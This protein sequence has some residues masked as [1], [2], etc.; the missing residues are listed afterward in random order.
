M[1]MD[2]FNDLLGRMVT[3]LGAASNATMV[4]TGDRLGLYHAL[5]QGPATSTE[6]AERTGTAERYV[7]EWLAAQAAGGYIDYSPADERYSLSPEQAFLLADN[8]GMDVPGA[9]YVT[10]A[11]FKALDRT[12]ENFRTGEGMEWGE[13]DACLFCGT[14]RFFRAGYNAHLLSEWLPALDGA[15]AKLSAGG[16]VLDVGCGHGSSTLLMARAYPASQFI[17]I[18]YHE[19]SIETARMKAADAGLTNVQFTVADAADFEERNLDLVAFF[20]SLHDMADPLAA[21]RHARAS[22]KSDGH[23]MVVEPMAGDKVEDNLNPVGRIFYAASAQFCV[24]VSLAKKGPALG[25]QAGQA[26]LEGI[27][28]DAGFSEVRRATETPFNMILEARP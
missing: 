7:R 11:M 12:A 6:L 19:A 10:A 27:L 21:A 20:D 22:L 13:H 15:T 8:N 17:G 14:D 26:R 4:L 16:R 24:P 3:D 23:L 25:A 9:Y 1:N 28:R 18:D 2:R 5:T